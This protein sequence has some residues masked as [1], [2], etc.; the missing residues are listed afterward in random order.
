MLHII[1]III[2]NALHFPYGTNQCTVW[3][4]YTTLM[5]TY[6]LCVCIYTTV[7]ATYFALEESTFFSQEFFM[8]YKV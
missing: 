5:S 2:V 3:A 6:G 4:I 1:N 8:T 7:H